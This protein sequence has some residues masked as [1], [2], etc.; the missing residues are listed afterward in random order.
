MKP[1]LMRVSLE[2]GK[3]PDSQVSYKLQSTA[4]V[5]ADTS[6]GERAEVACSEPDSLKLTLYF[7]HK[8][9]RFYFDE[10]PPFSLN[11][12]RNSSLAQFFDLYSRRSGVPMSFTDNSDL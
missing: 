1:D 2:H 3:P 11:D 12:I 9:K 4:K 7:Q 10:G 5:L 8:D 6:L